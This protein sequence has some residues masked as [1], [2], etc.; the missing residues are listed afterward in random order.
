ML[1]L[2][3]KINDYLWYFSIIY[4]IF[5]NFIRN[6]INYL[7]HHLLLFLGYQ[8]DQFLLVSVLHEIKQLKSFA[9]GLQLLIESFC[10]K[11]G[12]L[13]FAFELLNLT[14]YDLVLCLDDVQILFCLLHNFVQLCYLFLQLFVRHFTLL[15]LIGHRDNR[16]WRTW[17]FADHQILK[18]T[19]RNQTHLFIHHSS[20]FTS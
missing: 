14:A 15:L 3:R 13:L 12:L 4:F 9:L 1:L 7:S 5:I 6:I 11:I 18:F 16:W 10:I 19:R 2:A 20:V 8:G 17:A